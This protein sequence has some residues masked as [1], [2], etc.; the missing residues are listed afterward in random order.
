MV[1]VV[2]GV[3]QGIG[4]QGGPARSDPTAAVAVRGT[5]S[6]YLLAEQVDERIKVWNKV[7]EKV[8]ASI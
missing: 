3:L 7:W 6:P 1:S 4:S 2:L 5:A 8:S